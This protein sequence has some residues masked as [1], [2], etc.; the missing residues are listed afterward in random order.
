MDKYT[1]FRVGKLVRDKALRNL[2]AEGVVVHH[3]ILPKEQMIKLLKE[4]LVEEAIE[5]AEEEEREALIE[6]MADLK[7]VVLSLMHE[8]GIHEGEIEGSRI[9]KSQTTGAFEKALYIEKVIVEKGS[10]Q[11]KH[12]LKQPHK[13]PII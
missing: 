13:Y 11:E 12:F 4:K 1:S 10:E 5:V 8:L 2:E 7:Q 3:E 9:R 6:E